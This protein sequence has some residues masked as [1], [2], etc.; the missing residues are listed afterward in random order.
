LEEVESR[1]EVLRALAALTPRQRMGL[2]L[3]DLLDYPSE[4]AGYLMGVKA[5]TVR[6]LVAQAR[7]RLRDHMGGGIDA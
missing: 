3:M 7:A 2:V 5:A 4:Q 6:V 1:D